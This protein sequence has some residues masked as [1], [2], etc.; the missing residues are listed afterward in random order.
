MKNEFLDEYQKK[1]SDIKNFRGTLKDKVQLVIEL[2][3]YLKEKDSKELSR[4]AN[5][6]LEL[7]GKSRILSLQRQIFLDKIAISLVYK[8][9]PNK[10]IPIFLDGIAYYNKSKDF[11]RA[12]KVKQCLATAYDN[13][14]LHDQATEILTELL[15]YHS[16]EKNMSD[17][18]ATLVGLSCSYA[19]AFKYKEAEKILD[20]F[21]EKYKTS[22]NEDK[23]NLGIAYANYGGLFNAKNEFHNAIKY[24]LLSLNCFTEIGNLR[25]ETGISLGLA[26]NYLEI[27]DSTNAIL[28]AEKVVTIAEKQHF[29][30][31]LEEAYKILAQ[32][33]ENKNL[34]KKALVNLKK[35]YS[36]REK[37]NEVSA[38]LE[39]LSKVKELKNS[40]VDEHLCNRLIAS[41]GNKDALITINKPNG[42]TE[43]IKISSIISVKHTITG[44]HIEVLGSK[45]ILSIDKF[46]EIINRI[47]Q[48]VPENKF[49]KIDDKH[50]L[51]NSIF[52][53]NIDR[54]ARRIEITVFDK[55]VTYPVTHRAFKRILSIA[56]KSS[57]ELF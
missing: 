22:G 57:F 32:Q 37:R 18:L 46:S 41:F 1:Q 4:W 33:Y 36:L 52:I 15:K 29:G 5:I 21:F 56:K 49:V 6:G 53:T 13:I 45:K 27:S 16:K 3:S 42:K 7:V 25:L 26:Q 43:I 10:A 48:R 28:Y 20:L 14:G 12:S 55:K 34:L 38:K 31:Y 47:N 11:L 19:R 50:H 23:Y 39:L 30:E 8:N 51:V 54:E 44:L 35:Y 9:E 2:T 17:V 24:N 40:G